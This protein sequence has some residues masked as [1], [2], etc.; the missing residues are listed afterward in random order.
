[1]K[2]YSKT[3]YY[4]KLSNM[5]ETVEKLFGETKTAGLSVD[6]D[7]YFKAIEQLRTNPTSKVFKTYLESQSKALVE[8][9]KRIYDGVE[10]QK[11]LESVEIKGDVKEANS[12]LKEI[13]DINGK[14]KN[15]KGSTNDLLDRRDALELKLSKFANT[16]IT[17]T[18]DFYEIKIGGVSVL[19]GNS[20]QGDLELVNKD[21]KQIDRF[22]YINSLG[23]VLDSLK[24]NEDG[25]AKT[26]YTA[27][28]VITYKLNND[29]KL[30]VSIRIGETVKGNWDNDPTTPD[31]EQVVTMDNITRALAFK[32]NND[33]KL[34]QYV[35]AYNGDDNEGKTIYEGDNRGLDTS[36]DKYL[37]VESN[38]KGKKYQFTG[39][40][41]VE[42]YDDSNNITQREILFKNES[43][44]Q[45]AQSDTVLKSFEQE[46]DLS[47]GSIKAQLENL[48][49]SSSK[50]K[51][52]SYLD[53]LDSFAATLVDVYNQYIKTDDKKYVYGENA[54]KGYN[55]SNMGEIVSLGL[56][57]GSG[58]KDLTFNA[59]AVSDLTKEQI[60]YM[61]TV[62]WKTDLSFDGK[63]QN[64]NDPNKKSLVEFLRNLKS[65]VSQ[66]TQT[67]KSEQ[68]VQANIAQTIGTSYN[69]VV[70]VNEDEEMIN[71]MKLQ[72][73][74]SANSKIITAVDQMIQTILG[75]KT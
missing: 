45:K 11:S 1:M 30:S 12:I 17:R 34:S 35:T 40:I 74:Y 37:R 50:D 19:I 73:A 66:D 41:S 10:Q 25:S 72:A 9:L 61:A 69:N 39:K 33:P 28:D 4:D 5:L 58:V 64:P 46:I 57:S 26:A 14:L 55:A 60:D 6:L 7:N 27:N 44:S 62:Q 43:Q 13:A 31:T 38:D 67:S 32:I 2:E 49:T 68:E 47:S 65:N 15:F 56:F 59:S 22:N 42:R 3:S 23:N 70:K 48:S 54:S 71:L 18:E 75:M 21:T 16:D 63:V 52:Q 36:Y 8:S 24:Y 29:D 53:T 20:F 51:I